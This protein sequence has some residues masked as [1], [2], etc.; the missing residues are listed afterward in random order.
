[1]AAPTPQRREYV[2][3]AF[4]K[5]SPEW[6]RLDADQKRDGAA[7]VENIVNRYAEGMMVRPY[8][9][10]GMRSDSDICFWTASHELSSI[11]DFARDFGSTTLG[12]LSENTHSFLA[13]TKRSTYL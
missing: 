5:T 2:R 4:Y 10:V 8:S 13:M 11:Q 7:E 1:M 12:A 9:T 6:R 3:F